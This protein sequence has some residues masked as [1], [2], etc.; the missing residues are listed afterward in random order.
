MNST[1]YMIDNFYKFIATVFDGEPNYIAACDGLMDAHGD[2]VDQYKEYW[3]SV[4]LDF[5]KAQLIYLLTFTKLMGERS[6]NQSHY[7]VEENYNTYARLLPEVRYTT[8]S[9]LKDIV[10][11]LI[12][13]KSKFVP[14]LDMSHTRYP[15]EFLMGN[16]KQLE[17]VVLVD[18]TSFGAFCKSVIQSL[19][20]L[21]GATHKIRQTVKL[22]QKI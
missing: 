14:Q 9:Y 16:V 15:S 17:S 4:G 21:A 19:D 7:W 20:S 18:N 11:Y 8:D 5:N 22:I 12:A 13:N 10:A 6:K 3:E 2:K 1:H